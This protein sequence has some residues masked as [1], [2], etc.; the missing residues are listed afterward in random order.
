[1][2]IRDSKTDDLVYLYNCDLKCYTDN[3]DY[4]L[5][6]MAG[7]CFGIKVATVKN[8]VVGFVVYERDDN[9]PKEVCIVKMG[10][11]PAYRRRRIATHLVEAIVEFT[12]L[13]EANF[14]SLM[15]P[16]AL[17]SPGNDDDVSGFLSSVGFRATVPLHV[18]VYPAPGNERQAGVLWHKPC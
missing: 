18:N 4:E 5:W 7:E 10:V 2:T 14:I 12:R 15:T 16:E 9:D 13:I 11:K 17:I 1:M 6:R 8:A 3:W